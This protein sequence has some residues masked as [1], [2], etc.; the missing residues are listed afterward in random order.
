MAKAG[1]TD[2]IE[3]RVTS[4][5]PAY[6]TSA[7]IP[8]VAVDLLIRGRKYQEALRALQ[9]AL[10]RFPRSV[11]L[12]QLRG[13]ALRRSKLL[14]D[15]AY[16]LTLLA[17]E[18]H[19]DVETLGMLAS[20]WADLWELRLA[21]GDSSAARD[22]LEHSRTL[23]T[24]G[25]RKVPSDT[26]TGINAAAKSVLLGDLDVARALA[27]QVLARLREAA[28]ARGGE[29]SQDY[30]VRVTEP[31]ALLIKGEWATALKLYHEARVAHQTEKGSIEAT[32]TQV[33]RLLTVL[34]P[35]VDLRQQLLA[36]FGLSE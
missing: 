4:D 13:L 27:D 25:F 21:A 9:E 14:D 17:E 16:E 31:E 1:L 24:E 6:T 32:G 19:R 33:R 35:P 34:S 10:A 26:Y 5:E 12:R 36:E 15:A 11:R 23:Y 30:W 3:A 29:P 7:T 20:V 22:A 2:R 8:A 28:D 18:G